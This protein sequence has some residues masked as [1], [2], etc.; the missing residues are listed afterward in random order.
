MLR[1]KPDTKWSTHSSGQFSLMQEETMR[2]VVIIL[3]GTTLW[4]NSAL[5]QSTGT[6]GRAD[7]VTGQPRGN[8]PS[9]YAPLTASERWKL[10]FL[11]AFGPGA[12][13]RAGAVGGIRQWQGTPKEWR[14]GPEA[15]G[16]RFG[17]AMAQHVIQKTIESG[18]AAIL[19]EDNRY[20][21]LH[22]NRL[23][24]TDEACRGVHLCRAEQRRAR[25]LR[26]FPFWRH[27][28]CGIH[29]PYLAT[30]QHQHFR[31]CSREIRV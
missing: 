14:G 24:E 4:Q 7:G 31:R 12:I 18:A 29:F 13:L 3:L 11:G 26:V 2:N 10:Y 25:A 16:D 23:L 30:A 5:A 21:T 27:G 8:L 17:S 22:R 20:Y 19:H 1:K 28:E 6:S 9:D 15:Y